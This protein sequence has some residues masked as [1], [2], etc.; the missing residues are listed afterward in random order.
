MVCISPTGLHD[1]YTLEDHG[2]AVVD[3]CNRCHSRLVTRRDDYGRTDNRVY[4][5]EHER[6]FLQENDRRFVV[7]YGL[8]DEEF[9][10]EMKK[11]QRY[12]FDKFYENEKRESFEKKYGR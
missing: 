10:E 5:K 3:V 7:E 11:D 1:Y 8:K 2:D 4:V 12:A 6:D 9:K